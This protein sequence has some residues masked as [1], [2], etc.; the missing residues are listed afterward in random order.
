MNNQRILT[1]KY[2]NNQQKQLIMT[3]QLANEQKQNPITLTQL[4]KPKITTD[5]NNN[6][7]TNKNETLSH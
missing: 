3:D 6:Q 2:M 5:N 1:T 4:E 7:L